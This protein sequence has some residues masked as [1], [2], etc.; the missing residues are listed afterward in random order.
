MEPFSKVPKK[1]FALKRLV[2]IELLRLRFT[3]TDKC[4]GI[5]SNN[6]L[7]ELISEKGW[8][9]NITSSACEGVGGAKVSVSFSSAF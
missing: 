2:G 3:E 6:K 1:L 7:V 4:V 5:R 8:Q 9:T